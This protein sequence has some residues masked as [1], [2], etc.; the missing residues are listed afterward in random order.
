MS[1]RSLARALLDLFGVEGAL[2]HRGAL[3]KQVRVD[4]RMEG[5]LAHKASGER[6]QCGAQGV[7]RS[8]TLEELLALRHCRECLDERWGRG[9]RL[10]ARWI[11]DAEAERVV[12]MLPE[13]AKPCQGV[14][15]LQAEPTPAQIGALETAHCQHL[16][17]IEGTLHRAGL[18]VSLTACLEDLQGAL[19]AAQR[20]LGAR[21]REEDGCAAALDQI[22]ASM[23][24]A[25]LD[26]KQ[27]EFDE[28][29]VLVGVAPPL[30]EWSG[31]R[32]LRQVLAAHSLRSDAE[33]TVARLP[34]YVADHLQRSLE[35]STRRRA[36]TF[37][38]SAPA[39]ADEVL[40]QTAAALWDPASPALA[41][42]VAAIRTAEDA[43]S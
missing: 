34:R 12:R 17:W 14:A 21:L 39:P 36:G 40:A 15:A 10:R 33:A 4:V 5:G 24:P 3:V 38:V 19:Q 6:W 35:I 28:T 42:L 7:K 9:V 23:L 1:T 30:G 31:T 18:G 29:P 13:L 26:A 27:F 16:R 22:K 25:T 2:S 37:L 8:C 32:A 41:S 43:L 11:P 20:A